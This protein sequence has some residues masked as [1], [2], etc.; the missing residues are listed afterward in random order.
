VDREKEDLEQEMYIRIYDAI[1]RCDT[2]L[3]K[4]SC[5]G[6]LYMAS[7][8]VMISQVKRSNRQ[9]Q[10]PK[11]KMMYLETPLENN[12]QLTVADYMGNDPILKSSIPDE[13]LDPAVIVGRQNLNEEIL[14]VFG[15]LLSEKERNVFSLLGKE[16]S[17]EQMADKL[18][19]TPKRIDNTIQR[20]KGKIKE[21]VKQEL[22]Y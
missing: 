5:S 15:H 6:L 7:E 17:Y 9:Y 10:V 11:G 14:N 12:A 22:I 20:I 2:S 16:L 8:R 21:K 1:N 4:A 18:N 3:G 13:F 19:T